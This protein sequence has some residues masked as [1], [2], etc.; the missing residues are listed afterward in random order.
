MA[1]KDIVKHQFKTGF[2]PKRNNNG[3]PRKLISSLNNIGYNKRE[4]T[5]SILNIFALS[6]AEIEGIAENES[7]SILE[8]LVAKALLKDF[9]KGSIYNI[10]ALMNRAYGKPKETTSIEKDNKIEIVF[11]KGKTIL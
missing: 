6:K 2:D 7:Y 3:A 5:D 9:I 8:R 11:V 10:D 1:S 4:I